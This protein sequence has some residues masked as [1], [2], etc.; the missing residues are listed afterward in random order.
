MLSG[1]YLITQALR[2]ASSAGLTH[3]IH[4]IQQEYG[5]AIRPFFVSSE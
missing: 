4:E 2:C 3:Q 1:E 5:E